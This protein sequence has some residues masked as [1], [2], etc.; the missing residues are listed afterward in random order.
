MTLTQG[1]KVTLLSQQN[2]LLQIEI[3]KL[4]HQVQVQIPQQ[5]M[6]QRDEQAQVKF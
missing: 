2:Q 6:T 4:L 5:R 1:L 3:S